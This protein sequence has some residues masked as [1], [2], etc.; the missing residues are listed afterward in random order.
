[1]SF[2]RVWYVPEESLPPWMTTCMDNGEWVKG[3]VNCPKCQ[4]RV[5]SYSFVTGF[6]CPC[7]SRVVPPIHIVKSKVDFTEMCCFNVVDAL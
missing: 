1:V 3:K 5:G 4:A 6:K 7:G 2:G